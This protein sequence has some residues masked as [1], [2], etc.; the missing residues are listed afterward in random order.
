MR[1]GWDTHQIKLTDVRLSVFSVQ[2]FY[3]VVQKIDTV[4]AAHDAIV[5]T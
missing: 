4:G 5:W 2:W 1:T 3:M